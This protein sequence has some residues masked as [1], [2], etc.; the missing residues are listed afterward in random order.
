MMTQWRLALVAAAT[1]A[2][3]GSVE[4]Q[5][6]VDQRHPTATS[7]L[8]EIHLSSGSLRV[9]GWSRGEVQVTG[10]VRRGDRVV[11]EGNRELE[12]RV[13][14]SNGRRAGPASLEVRIPAGKA[15]EVAAGAASLSISGMTGDV[16]TQNASGSVTV[17]GS[18]RA[19]EVTVGSG[20]VTLNGNAQSFTVNSMSGGIT[21][22]GQVRQ[23]LEINAMSGAVDV[24]GRA[25]QTE[26][27]SLSG[28]VRV[29]NASGPLDVT[30]VSGTV[31]IAG[32]RL[33]G[34][35][36]TVSGSMLI[37]GSL[38]GPL[39]LETHS[40]QIEL[41]LPNGTAAQ[42]TATTYSGGFESDFPSTRE[43]RH[44]RHVTIGRGGP[45]VDITSFSGRVKLMRR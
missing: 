13:E 37:S 41:Q 26:I 38:G 4:A 36:E 19:V 12:V 33:R 22:R 40:G 43:G 25:G 10:T 21:V 39:S 44:E 28:G 2:A 45:Q 6:R 18:P 3:V 1:V 16:E 9:I 5:E 27:N 7:G 42:I 11:V 30:V 31:N 17:D 8:V 29:T 14:G 24:S 20:G 35:V 15:L 34:S 32:E 23:S